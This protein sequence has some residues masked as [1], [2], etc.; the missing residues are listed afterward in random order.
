MAQ[1]LIED[2]FLL[3]MFCSVDVKFMPGVFTYHVFLGNN[4]YY[5]L[6]VRPPAEQQGVAGFDVRFDPSIA[7]PRFVPLLLA[8]SEAKAVLDQFDSITGRSGG[9][10]SRGQSNSGRCFIPLLNDYRQN[11][12]R[13]RR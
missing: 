4:R 9:L 10:S 5:K 12:E 13:L 2:R 1:Q 11:P 6:R 3:R 8:D 7:G